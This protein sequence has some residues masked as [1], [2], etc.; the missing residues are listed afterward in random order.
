[1]SNHQPVEPGAA[2]GVI[3]AQ[4]I[5][6]PGTQL[7]M[8]TFHTGGVAG[9]DITQGL[10][11]AE[12][13]FEARKTLKSVQSVLSPLD[14]YVKSIS[15]TE[16]GTELVEIESSCRVIQIPTVLACAEPD[17]EV[18]IDGV[19]GMKSPCSGEVYILDDKEMF[20]IDSASGDRSYPLPPNAVPRV[21]N[22]EIV[23]AG[24]ALTKRFNIEGI[25]SNTTGTVSVI[26]ED[27]R[28]FQ[29]V[30]ANGDVQDYSI[31]YG[32]RM[33]V[34]PG[35][36]VKIG[37]QLTSRSRPI[38]VA[39][40]AGG[41][42]V[43]LAD[44]V[45]VYNPDGNAV[46]FPLTKDISPIKKRKNG[47]QVKLGWPLVQLEIL[48]QG[49]LFVEK[50]EAKGEITNVHL[51]PRSVVEV[52]QL[53]VVRVGDKVE[54][55]DLLTKGVVA[56]QALL[57]TAGVQKT[58]DYL[59]TEI[60]KVYK[61][62]GVD[63]NDKHIE[64]II[65]QTLNNARILAQGDSRFLVN[66]LVTLEEFQQEV[67]KLNEVNRLMDR[68]CKG[69]IGEEMAESIIADGHLIAGKGD[70]FTKEVLQ[71]AQRAEVSSVYIQKEGESM[72]IPIKNR[73]L[74]VA[75]RELLRISKAALHTKGWL[76]AASFQRTTKVLAEAALRGEVDELLSLKP[77]IIVGKRIPT[78]T[79]F[80]VLHEK[81][82]ESEQ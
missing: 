72:E 11:R 82:A 25:V 61:T 5:G 29:V 60:H 37:D 35:V 43:L 32:A 42:V 56:P 16:R 13:L 53:L 1:M 17:E 2:V 18:G 33:M 34:E 47:G 19:I 31:P 81:T 63:I 41:T 44:R 8:R 50:V 46:R 54:E 77:S 62:Q 73:E 51:R 4:S 75:E 39:A 14:G 69:V 67:R 45:I 55:G 27:E 22:G 74:P 12:E 20:V 76:S 71:A 59:L 52:D 28:A 68:T 49:A 36:K 26:N 58:R 66:D 70:P 48:H 9:V 40:E 65:R 80:R 6:E 21:K 10:P 24:D 3:A 57:E 30:A 7:T 64:I 15:S 78:G 23:S 79:G 38:F